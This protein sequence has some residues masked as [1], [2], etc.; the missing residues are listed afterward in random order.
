M[1]NTI[2]PDELISE[3]SNEF[4]TEITQFLSRTTATT[5]A[6]LEE[7]NNGGAETLY[8]VALAM[9]SETM[10][11]Y[12]LAVA[13]DALK[14]S[15][16]KDIAV[17]IEIAFDRVLKRLKYVSDEAGFDKAFESALETVSPLEKLAAT[18]DDAYAV[19]LHV[20]G[21]TDVSD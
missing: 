20:V 2:M 13:A 16:P 15:K 5:G 21:G 19:K 10:A 12:I 8:P 1:H 17:A 6:T 3:I 7:A 18:D 4:R 14:V 9:A 11:V